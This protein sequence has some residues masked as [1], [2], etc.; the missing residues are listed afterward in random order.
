MSAFVVVIP[1]RLASERLPRKPLLDIGGKT[2]IERVYRQ[3]ALSRAG[4]VIV[5]TDS[6]EIGSACRAF[7]AAVEM[8]RDDHASGTD[9]I[10][11]VAVRR[12]W[13]D[14]QIVI[15]V[16]GDEPLLPPGLI[17]QLASMLDNDVSAGMATLTTPLVDASEYADQNNVKVVADRQGRALYF[18]RA[19]IP[20]GRDGRVPEVVRRH[21]GLYAYRVACL[22]RLAAAPQAPMERAERLEQL[23]ALW[24]GERVVVADAIEPPARGVDTPEDLEFIRAAVNRVEATG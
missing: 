10:A 15:N 23:R 2:M 12:A 9:R 18:S 1:A 8:T 24:L 22:E 6:E 13:R 19:P 17:D 4:E 5:A 14:D 7:G 3:A 11:E 20:Y 21:V 16:Q